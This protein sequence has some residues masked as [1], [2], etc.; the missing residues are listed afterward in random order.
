M[1]SYPYATQPN[2]IKQSEY[3]A[4]NSCDNWRIE[5]VSMMIGSENHLSATRSQAITQINADSLS[6]K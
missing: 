6:I 1:L 3:Y 4:H 2:K 5:Q